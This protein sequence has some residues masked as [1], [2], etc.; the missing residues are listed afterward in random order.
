MRYDYTG[1]ASCVWALW[2]IVA[3]QSICTII[4]ADAQ[5]GATPLS[6]GIALCVYVVSFMVLAI[7][8]WALGVG[9]V[10]LIK[11]LDRNWRMEASGPKEHSP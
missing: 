4:K 8:M 7:P 5:D 6:S 1:L 2:M 3:Y 10:N 9:F 11:W